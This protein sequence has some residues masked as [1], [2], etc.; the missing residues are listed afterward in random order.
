MGICRIEDYVSGIRIS[1]FRRHFFSTDRWA[2]AIK[3]A[4]MANNDLRIIKDLHLEKYY[5]CSQMLVNEYTRFLMHFFKDKMNVA[6]EFVFENNGAKWRGQPLQ[7]ARIPNTTIKQQVALSQLRIIDMINPNSGE[8]LTVDEFN[9]K[10]GLGLGIESY[11]MLMA[12]ANNLIRKYDPDQEKCPTLRSVIKSTK[13]GS[14]RFREVLAK[15]SRKKVASLRPTKTRATIYDFTPEEE[16]EKLMYRTWNCS[17]LPNSVREYLFKLSQNLV[18][19]NANIAKFN[20]E[21]SPLCK[22]CLQQG[23]VVEEKNLHRYI[24]CPLTLNIFDRV[25]VALRAE[26]IL[27]PLGYLV[28]SAD[29]SYTFTARVLTGIL[30]YCIHKYRNHEQ[31]VEDRI[32]AEFKKIVG[33]MFLSNRNFKMKTDALLNEECACL[34]QIH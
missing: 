28:N 22:S 21:A 34:L 25:N 16:I 1:F 32:I 15:K 5:P 23:V 29:N 18:K 3:G 4:K 20:A 26:S 2:L 24:N 13:K 17:F 31:F 8:K 14:K 27:T 30:F 11:G 10:H 9:L 33:I 12:G 7:V 19:I 6:E